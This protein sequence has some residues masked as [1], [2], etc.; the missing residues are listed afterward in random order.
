METGS[1]LLDCKDNPQTGNPDKAALA[2]LSLAYSWFQFLTL[3][4]EIYTPC[5][6]SWHLNSTSFS[7]DKDSYLFRYMP[8]KSQITK[9]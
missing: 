9:I 5:L 3:S 8:R 7:K 1:L 4:N 2:L 6:H